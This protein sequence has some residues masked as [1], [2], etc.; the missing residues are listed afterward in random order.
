MP[1]P[2]PV[3]AVCTS[4]VLPPAPP[5]PPPLLAVLVVRAVVDLLGSVRAVC[6][7]AAARHAPRA[8]CGPDAP[9]AEVRVGVGVASPLLVR[10][11]P[12]LTSL[13]PPCLV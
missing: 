8:A 7:P 12:L 2:V 13:S 4:R 6:V 5:A 10:L 3:V 1:T 11:V 9:V